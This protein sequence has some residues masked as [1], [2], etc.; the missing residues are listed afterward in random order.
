[1]RIETRIALAV[2]LAA[3]SVAPAQANPDLVGCYSIK[4]AQ[5]PEAYRVTQSG[6]GYA[7]TEEGASAKPVQPASASDLAT[8]TEQLQ[9]VG[10]TD[11]RPLYGLTGDEYIVFAL[12]AEVQADGGPSRIGVYDGFLFDVFPLYRI[13]CR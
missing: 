2:L 11:A 5:G 13:P 8:V 1:M 7:L 6:A 9:S 3:L 4:G 10:V 12:S